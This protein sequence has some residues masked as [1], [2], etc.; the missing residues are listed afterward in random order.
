MRTTSV[1]ISTRILE[2]EL[3]QRMVYVNV[4]WTMRGVSQD[5]QVFSCKLVSSEKSL[6]VPV[7]PV[8][9]VVD[10]TQGKDMRNFGSTQDLMSVLPIKVCILN[11]VKVCVSKEDLVAEV[12]NGQSIGPDKFVFV[13]NDSSEV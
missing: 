11:V 10:D 1:V 6:Y 3:S 5:L 2:V 9:P 13:Q 7:C 8:K 4:V 12:V